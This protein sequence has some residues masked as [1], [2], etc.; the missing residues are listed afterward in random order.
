MRP[1]SGHPPPSA[2][3][4]R[5]IPVRLWPSA[6]LCPQGAPKCLGAVRGFVEPGVI[7]V[8]SGQMLARRGS[9]SWA[10]G[11]WFVHV[12]VYVDVG[13]AAGGLFPGVFGACGPG[14]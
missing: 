14:G 7:P 10:L 11:S 12:V 6:S 5:V 4:A 1:S 3:G 8:L 13:W 2:A 9:R